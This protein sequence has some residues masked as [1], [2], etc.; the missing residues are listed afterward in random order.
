[1]IRHTLLKV[2]TQRKGGQHQIWPDRP[3]YGKGL[4]IAWKNLSSGAFLDRLDI[5]YKLCLKKGTSS[6]FLP[7]APFFALTLQ[8][9]IG[10][11]QAKEWQEKIL[12]RDGWERMP[13]KYVHYDEL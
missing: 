9:R 7:F 13:P 10:P 3:L 1:M 11:P 4:E 2:G 6:L 5:P 12:M 8:I